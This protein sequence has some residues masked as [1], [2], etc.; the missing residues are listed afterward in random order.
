MRLDEKLRK[1]CESADEELRE[2][3]ENGDFLFCG[4]VLGCGSFHLD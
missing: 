3:R 2:V 4:D 1:V